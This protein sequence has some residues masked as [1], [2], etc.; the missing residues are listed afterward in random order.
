MQQL[1]REHSSDMQLENALRPAVDGKAVPATPSSKAAKNISVQVP[2]APTKL[3][4]KEA[5][6]AL[7]DDTADFV[8]ICE[9]KRFMAHKSVLESTSPYFARM[10]RFNGQVYNNAF[11]AK[12]HADLI[13]GKQQQRS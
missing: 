3:K 10:F 1:N 13:L 7:E 8:V 2:K 9:G 11:H 4:T 6:L 5:K 12:I